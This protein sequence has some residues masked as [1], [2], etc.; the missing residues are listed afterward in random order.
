MQ[1]KIDIICFNII[2][3][4]HLP[5]VADPRFSKVTLIRIP[6]LV[7]GWGVELSREQVVL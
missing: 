2:L 1:D 7:G 3:F 4:I 5:A 6:F